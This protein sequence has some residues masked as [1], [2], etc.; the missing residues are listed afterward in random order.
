M[1]YAAEEIY[2]DNGKDQRRLIAVTDEC[3]SRA[4]RN[5]FHDYYLDV[6]DTEEE[7]RAHFGEHDYENALPDCIREFDAC[8][9][10]LNNLLGDK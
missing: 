10:R 7:A 5:D 4:E 3:K 8:L 6:F 2:F 1:K 9:D